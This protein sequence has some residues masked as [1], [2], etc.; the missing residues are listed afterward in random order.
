MHYR[1]TMSTSDGNRIPFKVLSSLN[2]ILS[3]HG[4]GTTYIQHNVVN[5]YILLL[6]GHSNKQRRPCTLLAA[7]AHSHRINYICLCHVCWTIGHNVA[8]LS[9]IVALHMTKFC[10]FFLECR[11]N[12]TYLTFGV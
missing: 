11:V 6:S 12:S 7:V 9:T 4:S 5:S 1:V 8:L 3:H 2:Q 10:R